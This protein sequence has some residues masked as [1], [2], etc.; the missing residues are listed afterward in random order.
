[1]YALS[2]SLPAG[3]IVD[4][5][6]AAT[7]ILDKR[8]FGD[9]PPPRHLPTPPPYVKNDLVRTAVEMIN[10]ATDNIPCWDVYYETKVVT[11]QC[12]ASQGGKTA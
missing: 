8:K 10:E 9:R 6:K 5:E 12:S 3:H 2:P 11:D 4:D 1:M 7:Y